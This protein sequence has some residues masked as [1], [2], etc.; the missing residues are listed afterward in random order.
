MIEE[1]LLE[2]EEKRRFFFE[3]NP[4]RKDDYNIFKVLEITEK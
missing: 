1:L 2:V 3:K 4:N